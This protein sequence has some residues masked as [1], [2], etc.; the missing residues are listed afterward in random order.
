MAGE[1]ITATTLEEGKEELRQIYKQDCIEFKEIT[2]EEYEK[3]EQDEREDSDN[4]LNI[5]KLGRESTI[6]DL[7]YYKYLPDRKT[8]Y[9]IILKHKNGEETEDYFLLTPGFS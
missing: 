1:I 4:H 2:K 8:A 7:A 3:L 5:E 9:R 6:I